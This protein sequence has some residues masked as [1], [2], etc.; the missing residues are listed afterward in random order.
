M[1]ITVA[2][3]NWQNVGKVSE[4]GRYMFKFGWVTVTAEDLAIW[5]QY[6]E[7][8]FALYESPG[9]E[10]LNDEY[11]LGS[12]QLTQA[13]LPQATEPVAITAEID[14]SKPTIDSPPSHSAIAPDGSFDFD[15]LAESDEP[16]G[17][18]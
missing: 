15:P 2:R 4:P 16:K 5:S 9:P 14:Q 3:I 6:P 18:K 11:R 10:R 8:T 17:E 7:A 13:H 12:V 1:A